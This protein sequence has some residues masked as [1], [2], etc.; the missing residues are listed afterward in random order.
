[1]TVGYRR[2]E[3]SAPQAKVDELEQRFGRRLPGAY[4]DYLHEQDGGRLE[5]N[6]Q[7]AN[8]IFGVGDVPDWANLWHKLAVYADRVPPWLLPVANDAYG[9]LFCLSLRDS[10]EGS[11]W[12]WDHEEEADEGEPPAEDNLTHKADNW[13]AFLESLQPV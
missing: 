7:A 6:H 1:M 9:N 3:Q 5:D 2:K 13:T 11:V 8:T 10:D 12:F 4:R